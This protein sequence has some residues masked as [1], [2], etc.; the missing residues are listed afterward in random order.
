MITCIL[1]IAYSWES[2]ESNLPVVLVRF[3]NG[4]AKEI[5]R[6][7]VEPPLHTKDPAFEPNPSLEKTLTFLI[8]ATREFHKENCP[9]CKL[10]CLPTDSSQTV[11]NDALDSYVERVYCGHLFH[12]GCLKQYIREPPFPSGGKCCPAPKSHPRSDAM[13]RHVKQPKPN[14]QIGHRKKSASFSEGPEESVCGIRLSHDRWGL[15]VKLAEARWAQQQARV[16]ELEE[17]I[18]FMK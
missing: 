4:Q 10:P 16:R 5:A 6:Q 15:S 17:V 18:D 14:V 8:S 9:I 13:S 7:C 3:L 2:H 1:C 12:Q 11:T